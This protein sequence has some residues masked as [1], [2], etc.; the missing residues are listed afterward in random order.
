MALILHIIIA[1]ASVAFTTYVLIMP[2]HAKLKVSYGLI[3]ATLLSGTIL[4]FNEPATLL[5][6]CV[7]GF[8]YIT[9]ITAATSFAH[10]RLSRVSNSSI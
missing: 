10:V 1:L 8:T 3:V 9:V 2:S 7:S 4:V 5:Q 6:A